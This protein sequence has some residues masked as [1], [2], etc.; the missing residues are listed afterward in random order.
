M[1]TL[2]RSP[3]ASRRETRALNSS[4]CTLKFMTDKLL[5]T[6]LSS[7]FSLPTLA[8]GTTRPQTL[9]L[10]YNPMW[11]QRLELEGIELPAGCVISED[12][13]QMPAAD[14]VVFHIP[15]LRW[16]PRWRKRPGQLWVAWS[17]ECEQNYP[18]L[19]DP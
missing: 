3:G 19:R 15:S 9:L 1:R 6:H 7:Y 18:R 13:R 12:R 17:L 14:V 11:N 8:Q 2:P 10:F 16:L 5:V 4:G